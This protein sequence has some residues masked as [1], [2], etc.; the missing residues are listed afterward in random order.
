RLHAP[1]LDRVLVEEA[2]VQVAD[3]LF[4]GVGRRRGPG[5]RADF[6]DQIAYLDLGPIEQRAEGAVG[7]SVGRDVVPSQRPLTWPNRSSWGRAPASTLLRSIPE[8]IASTVTPP[9][10]HLVER[11]P[12]WSD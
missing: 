4:V 7:G 9:S 5:F 10:F 11:T 12:G 2:G 3:A 6:G 1:P 8:R